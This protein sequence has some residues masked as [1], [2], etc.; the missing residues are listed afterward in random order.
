MDF[1]ARD[2]NNNA[3]AEGL[4]PRFGAIRVGFADEAVYLFLVLRSFRVRNSTLHS[5][6]VIGSG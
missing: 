4:E 2:N 3:L 6:L 5:Y 1:R